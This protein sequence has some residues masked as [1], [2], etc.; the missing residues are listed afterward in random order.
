MSSSL[1]RKVF[2][3]NVSNFLDT[4]GNS[5]GE[6][7]MVDPLGDD[8]GNLVPNLGADFSVDP[9]VG[10]DLEMALFIAT[11]TSEPLRFRV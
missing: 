8:L 4:R 5:V 3:E 9:L 6:A 11:K 7:V 1:G 10:H 2:C